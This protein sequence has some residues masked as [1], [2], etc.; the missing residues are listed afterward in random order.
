[1]KWT[2]SLKGGNSEISIIFEAMRLTDNIC[3]SADLDGDE[4]LICLDIDT[5]NESNWILVP[6]SFLVFTWFLIPKCNVV[7]V[8]IHRVCLLLPCFFS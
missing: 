2:V 6:I 3:A 5:K 7:D 8:V 1:M 4:T